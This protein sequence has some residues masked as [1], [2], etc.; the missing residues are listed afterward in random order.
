[1][2]AHFHSVGFE[3]AYFS[4]DLCESVGKPV[5]TMPFVVVWERAAE[6]LQRM[7]GSLQRIDEAVATCTDFWSDAFRHL[8]TWSPNALVKGWTFSG[9]IFKHTGFPY[10]IWCNNET[11]TLQGSLSGS[12][13][14]ASFS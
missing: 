14:P 13:S 12:T 5:K 4:E 10:S 11:A 8:T 9:T 7:L 1:M 2:S 6:H 3:V